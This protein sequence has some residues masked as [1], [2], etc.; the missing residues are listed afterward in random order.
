MTKFLKATLVCTLVTL[1]GCS[2][3]ALKPSGSPG[4]AGIWDSNKNQWIDQPTLVKNLQNAKYIVVG[5]LH[6]GDYL[7]DRLLEI[8]KELRNEEW[9]E[10]V[11]LD[12][13]Q[14]RH[15]ADEMTWLEQLEKQNPKLLNRYKALIEWLE[16]EDIPLIA[17][18]VPLNKLQSMKQQDA[19]QWLRQQTRKTLSDKQLEQ[20]KEILAGSHPQAHPQK[21]DDGAARL[22]YMLAAQQLQDYFMARLLQAVKV[23]SVIITRAFHARNDLGVVPYIKAG[24]PN[25]ETTSL[26][27]VST[28]DSGADMADI[29][30]SMAGQYDYVWLRFSEKGLLLAPNQKGDTAD[31]KRS[32]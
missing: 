27:M 22:E 19:Q 30:K 29:L 12:V 25:T 21:S 15:L 2:Q 8:L 5:E 4:Q 28:M 32:K 11:A 1:A 23:N 10:A 7:R 24:D 9:L 18:A 31:D 6:Q 14:S 13:V 26:L 16:E 20:L 17:A 3:F